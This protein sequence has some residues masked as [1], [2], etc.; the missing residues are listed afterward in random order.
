MRQGEGIGGEGAGIACRVCAEPG[1]IDTAHSRAV[2]TWPGASNTVHES[3]DVNT[4]GRGTGGGWH[5]MQQVWV[6]TQHKGM[7][8]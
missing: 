1:S 4:V 3:W 5:D 2:S 6:G 7:G 8:V